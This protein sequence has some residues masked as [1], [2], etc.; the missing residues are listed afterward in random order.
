MTILKIKSLLSLICTLLVVL[1]F[2]T[3]VSAK[4]PAPVVDAYE[5]LYS[6]NKP[7]KTKF[8]ID[9]ATDFLGLEL[10][11]SIRGWV[12][13]DDKGNS[14]GSAVV[15]TSFSDSTK[16]DLAQ[17]V[18]ITIRYK[19]FPDDNT[20]YFS[21]DKLPKELPASL[22]GVRT[23]VWYRADNISEKD[24]EK[25]NGTG[26]FTGENFIRA[27]TLYPA[28]VYQAK[29]SSG[30]NYVYAS[31][32]NKAMLSNF[33][34]ERTR[35]DGQVLT[36]A[37]TDVLTN[38]NLTR[39][40]TLVINKKS[41]LPISETNYIDSKFTKASGVV[42]FSFGGTTL[43]TPPKGALPGAEYSELFTST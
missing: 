24:I 37:A 33:L 7:V 28:L 43:V 14:E 32:V 5:S 4:M 41:G 19:L 11:T 17:K 27:N 22:K 12:Y 16:R 9:S 34:T 31:S 15:V 6:S 30:K 40:G 20:F 21:F 26:P 18:S 23:K 38:S 39:T 13:E 1:S 2:P 29:G 10:G 3:F 25:L 8:A 35:L 36:P 42:T